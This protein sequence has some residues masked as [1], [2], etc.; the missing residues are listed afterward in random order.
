[1]KPTAEAASAA[2]SSADEVVALRARVLELEAQLAE[3]A[4]AT[5]EIVAR[6][7]EKLYWLERWHVDLDS[8]MRR[9][10]AETTLESLK[11][12]RALIRRARKA[13]RK[14]LGN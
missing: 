14:Y 5:N 2:A 7:Q 11:K 4:R 1:M 9:P 6:S 10:G 3:Q 12:V 8:V 13:K